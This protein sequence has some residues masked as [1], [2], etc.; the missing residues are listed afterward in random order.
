ME[1]L[2]PS[3][4]YLIGRDT[5]EGQADAVL[6]QVA[7]M[8]KWSLGFGPERE[9]RGLDQDGLLP[10]D[11]LAARVGVTE[12]IIRCSLLWLERKGLL[13]I[14]GWEGGDVARIKPG[15]GREDDDSERRPLQEELK[16]LLAE[17]R[18]YRRFF[19]RAQVRALGL[20]AD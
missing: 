15:N 7:G 19:L 4:L 6:K 13:R 10:I 16:E 5:A 12:E 18:A 8:A 14:Q 11:R 17:M 3:E 1:R 2:A 20:G 9:L